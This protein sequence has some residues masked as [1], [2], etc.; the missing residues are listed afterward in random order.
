MVDLL[1]FENAP[2]ALH[3]GVLIAMS[4]LTRWSANQPIFCGQN[5]LDTQN[6]SSYTPAEKKE[7]LINLIPILSRAGLKKGPESSSG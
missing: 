5:R 6:P 3:R 1:V 2:E 4:L 7:V